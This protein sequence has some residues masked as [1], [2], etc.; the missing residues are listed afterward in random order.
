MMIFRMMLINSVMTLLTVG[1]PQAANISVAG[2]TN[3]SMPGKAN[4]ALFR[5]RIGTTRS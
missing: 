1:T 2:A 4:A 3:F 5:Q